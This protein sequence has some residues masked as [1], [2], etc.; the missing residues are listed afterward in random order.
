[1]KVSFDPVIHVLT[2]AICSPFEY[3][4][5][6]EVV[7]ELTLS[8]AI[9]DKEANKLIGSV[10]K[11]R[12]V[13]HPV[14]S[15]IIF[16]HDRADIVEEL[17]DASSIAALI[18]GGGRTGIG[19]LDYLFIGKDKAHAVVDGIDLVAPVRTRP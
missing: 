12:Q 11:G 5:G 4:S 13:F 14:R 1:M 15:F 8:D 17:V 9:L 16:D 10:I 3:A 2:A 7:I 19:S 18:P 6:Y